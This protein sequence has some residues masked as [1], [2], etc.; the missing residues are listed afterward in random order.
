MNAREFLILCGVGSC[1]AMLLSFL[2][3][4][5]RRGAEL[6]MRRFDVLVEALRDPSLDVATRADLLR[7]IARDHVGVFGWIWQRLQSPT[8]WR[9][10]WFGAGW[11]TMLLSGAALA[12]YAF[13]LG[14]VRTNDLSAIVMTMTLG[15]GMLT[16]PLAL[17]ELMRRERATSRP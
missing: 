11:M 10:L 4:Q 12:T 7:A 3:A 16:L 8:L 6:R 14:T 15:F 2:S 17:R 13:R 1:L 5:R 9:V